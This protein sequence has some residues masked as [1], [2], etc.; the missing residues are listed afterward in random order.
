MPQIHKNQIRAVMKWKNAKM[1]M[2]K[3]DQYFN[4]VV[5][6]NESMEESL[7]YKE[8]TDMKSADGVAPWLLKIKMPALT[9]MKNRASINAIY[10]IDD[11]A[12]KKKI[13]MVS[14]QKMDPWFKEGK[15]HLGKDVVMSST[16]DYTCC[17]ELP[18][19]EGCL[20]ENV[21]D[22]GLAGSVPAWIIKMTA[23]TSLSN[24]ELLGNYLTDNQMPGKYGKTQRL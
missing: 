12:N 3:F 11:P 20:L 6:L 22:I 7:T 2:E 19:G 8:L 9:F 18:N 14:N 1:T 17:T 4:N 16:M 15:K 13:V 21:Y 23:K 24:L 10:C 5:A